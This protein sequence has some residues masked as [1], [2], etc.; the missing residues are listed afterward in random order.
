MYVIQAIYIIIT[1]SQL[2]RNDE[3]IFYADRT[4]ATNW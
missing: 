3:Y 4:R 1:G 2:I